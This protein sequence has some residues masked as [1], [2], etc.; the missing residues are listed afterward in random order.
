MGFLDRRSS[1]KNRR[2]GRKTTDESEGGIYD[3]S[4]FD[5][6]RDAPEKEEGKI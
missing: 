1:V 3:F 5:L 2:G 4:I 6:G